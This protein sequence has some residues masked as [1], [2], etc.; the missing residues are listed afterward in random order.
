MDKIKERLEEFF[1]D[2]VIRVFDPEDAQY[3]NVRITGRQAREFAATISKKL[4][5][6]FNHKNK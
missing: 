6:T 3:K 1:N 4:R 5:I 2:K